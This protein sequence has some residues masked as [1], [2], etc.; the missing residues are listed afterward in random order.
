M[1]VVRNPREV[2]WRMPF[3][4]VSLNVSLTVAVVVV[5]VV[6]IFAS[7]MNSE[8]LLAK[9]GRDSPRRRHRHDETFVVAAAVSVVFFSPVWTLFFKSKRID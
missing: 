6:V 8:T 3:V 4:L 5:V 7:C 2:V 1:E 9:A